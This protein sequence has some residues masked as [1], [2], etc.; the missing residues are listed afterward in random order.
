MPRGVWQGESWRGI[1]GLE[2]KSLERPCHLRTRRSQKNTQ[3][4]LDIF[5]NRC[6]ILRDESIVCLHAHDERPRDRRTFTN[7]SE[8][9]GQAEGSQ[10][11][12]PIDV[13]DSTTS[14]PRRSLLCLPRE[15]RPF[16]RRPSRNSSLQD[17]GGG[18]NSKGIHFMNECADSNCTLATPDEEPPGQKE[19]PSNYLLNSSG[20]SQS[21]LA[22]ADP[23]LVG[24]SVDFPLV[25]V[26]SL[27]PCA[28]RSA[29]RSKAGCN[30]PATLSRGPSN[31]CSAGRRGGRST[32]WFQHRADPG[33]PGAVLP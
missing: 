3:V 12:W 31:G 30:S 4:G 16:A 29:R 6:L 18:R 26:D 28:G 19:P 24:A 15:R 27:T 9:H 10:S 8:N 33:V 23:P 20:Y 25:S 1:A 11:A 7:S 17:V 32:S 22:V 13:F 2:K 5:G 21:S 14:C